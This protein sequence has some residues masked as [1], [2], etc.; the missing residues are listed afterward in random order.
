MPENKRGADERRDGRSV[1]SSPLED[2]SSDY[3][4][5]FRTI[6]SKTIT[7]VPDISEMELDDSGPEEDPPEF[8]VVGKTH[9][10]KIALLGDGAVGKTSLRRAYLGESF[11]SE[12]LLTLGSDFAMKT[13]QVEDKTLKFQIWDL[14]GQQRFNAVRKGYYLGCFGGLLVF[15]RTRPETLEHTMLWLNELWKS[16]G[17]GPVPFLLL[18]NKTDIDPR[19]NKLDKKAKMWAELFSAETRALK[20]FEVHYLQTSAKTGLNVERAFQ[21]LGRNIISWMDQFQA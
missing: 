2:N 11:S 1:S 4:D 6:S 10:V 3:L 12:Y 16:S 20:G 14:S 8:Q 7:D 13:A 19:A 21:L 5:F 17:R 18:G 15:D 9:A